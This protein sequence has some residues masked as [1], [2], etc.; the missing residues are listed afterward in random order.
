MQ[1]QTILTA[2]ANGSEAI[3]ISHRYWTGWALAYYQ[4]Y[5]CL[6]FSQITD[7]ISIEEIRQMYS[8]YHE[9]D[10]RQFCDRMSELYAKR[11]KKTNLKQKRLLAGISQSQLAALSGIPV[12]TIQQ[13]EQGQKDINK[14]N[15][16]YLI[17]LSRVL[18]CDP[19]HLL[20]RIPLR[21]NSG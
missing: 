8:P 6:S 20:E 15:A 17:S 21:N 5:T 16:E 7:L 3:C 18:C 11:K 4:W 12:R 10:I 9:M 14:A 1:G 13:Y 19:Q 2:A